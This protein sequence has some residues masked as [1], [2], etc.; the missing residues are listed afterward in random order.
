MAKDIVTKAEILGGEI[1]V[2]ANFGQTVKVT[3]SPDPYMGDTE[4]TPS[5]ETQVLATKKKFV[6]DDITIFPAPTETLSTTSNGTFTPSSGKVGFSQVDVNVVPDLRPLSV[7]ENG[8]YQPDGF[9]G[10]SD[11][12]VDVEP[13]LTSLSVTENGLYLPESGT[14]GFDRVSVDVPQPSGSTAITENG[15]YD[16]EQFASAVVDVPSEVT[17]DGIADGSQP[18]GD[19]TLTVTEVVAGAFRDKTAITGI[20]APNCTTVQNTGFIG[21]SGV[22]EISFPKLETV[23]NNGF[24]NIKATNIVLPAI[25]VTGSGA[26]ASSAMVRHICIGEHIETI[27]ASCMNN[28]LAGWSVKMKG[29]PTSIATNAFPSNNAGDIYVP[30]SQGE[31][32]NAPWGATSATIHYDTV[33]DEEWNVI[34]ST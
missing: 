21:C 33:Y 4:V 2:R 14:D 7:S 12:T 6:Q 27:G 26:F 30:W 19:I 10:Y 3:V 20:N 8:S 29:K 18:S 5:A 24:T 22:T 11:V 28:M 34:S 17:F 23:G 31:V 25:R 32:A 1:D 9:D 16:V 15:T 13:N